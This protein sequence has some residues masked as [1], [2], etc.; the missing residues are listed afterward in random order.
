[1]VGPILMEQWTFERLLKPRTAANNNEKPI[2][3]ALVQIYMNGLLEQTIIQKKVLGRISV[4]TRALRKQLREHRRLVNDSRNKKVSRPEPLS[5]LKA[6]LIPSTT[7][8]LGLSYSIH[9]IFNTS[10]QIL[11]LRLCETVFQPGI[12]VRR[13]TMYLPRFHFFSSVL[14]ISETVFQPGIRMTMYLN[15]SKTVAL[16]VKKSDSIGMVKSLLHEEEG[17]PECLQQLFSKDVQLTDEQKLIDCGII[18]NSILH[19][20]IDNSVPRTLLVKRLYAKGASSIVM[21]IQ[22]RNMNPNRF[23]Y[24]S[25]RSVVAS[26]DRVANVPPKRRNQPVPHL[27]DPLGEHVSHAEFRV[28]FTTLAQSVATQN[29]RPPVI[30]ANPVANSAAAR[31]W[32]FTQMNP[33]SFFG[34]KSDEDP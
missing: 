5:R 20:H 12:W 33:P 13:R 16:R 8:S 25:S 17:I 23:R 6:A 4:R 15:V 24:M 11:V 30:P 28:T 19:A 34:S 1:M 26:N 31:I 22:E 9:V 32:D 7:Q 21:D 18:E 2:E 3:I 10:N 29:E 14:R 27:E